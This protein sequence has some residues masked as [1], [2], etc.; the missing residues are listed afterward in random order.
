MKLKNMDVS[1]RGVTRT[2]EFDPATPVSSSDEGEASLE[3][4]GE[5]ET[6][7]VQ[8]VSGVSGAVVLV[9]Y[10]VNYRRSVEV[11]LDNLY[12]E[13]IDDEQDL[14]ALVERGEFTEVG[15]AIESDVQDNFDDSWYNMTN[16]EVTSVTDDDGNDIEL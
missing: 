8:L 7:E 15:D 13:D 11:E 12:D 16:V 2:F 1:I 10:E 6:T 4:M 5:A 9:E 3:L 14:I